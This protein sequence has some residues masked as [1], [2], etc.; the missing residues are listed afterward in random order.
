MFNPK[1]LLLFYT[2]IFVLFCGA[3]QTPSKETDAEQI[4]GLWKLHIME[5]QDSIGHWQ[6]YNDGLQGMLLYDGNGHGA[7][8]LLPKDYTDTDINFI[9]TID[10]DYTDSVSYDELR[11]KAQSYVYIAQYKVLEDKG[12]IQHTRLTASNPEDWGKTVNRKYHFLGDTLVLQPAESEHADLRL[13]WVRFEK[14]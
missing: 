1:A 2:V 3:C 10:L 12:I 4:S 8:H 13:K 9:G 7:L 5:Q 11:H 14:P 6:E